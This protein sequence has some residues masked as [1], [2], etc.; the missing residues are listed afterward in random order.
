MTRLVSPLFQ[1]LLQ[2]NRGGC[3]SSHAT[4]VAEPGSVKDL[5]SF[6]NVYLGFRRVRSSAVIVADTARS[7]EHLDRGLVGDVLRDAANPVPMNKHEG[8]VGI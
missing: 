5:K 6:D 1:G 4:V 7:R 2:T 3:W 8:K